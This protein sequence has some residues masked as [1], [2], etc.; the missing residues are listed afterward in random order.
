MTDKTGSLAN[1]FRV[2]SVFRGSTFSAGY[3]GVRPH[4]KEVSS[5]AA[6]PSRTIQPPIFF[7]FT[8]KTFYRSN[9]L[10]T[11]IPQPVFSSPCSSILPLYFLHSPPPHHTAFRRLA[12]PLI[13]SIIQRPRLIVPANTSITIIPP[14]PATQSKLTLLRRRQHPPAIPS[15][16]IAHQPTHATSTRITLTHTFSSQQQSCSR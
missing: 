1:H 8:I 9:F 12:L 5:T 6:I 10:F 13:R 3:N 4:G 7:P 11:I 14:T 15:P 2:F 16:S